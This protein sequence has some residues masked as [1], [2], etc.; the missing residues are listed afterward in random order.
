VTGAGLLAASV[1][2]GQVWDHVSP[3]AALLLGAALAFAASAL[4]ALGPHPAR[5]APAA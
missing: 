1:L 3:A 2:A 4:L 5:Q